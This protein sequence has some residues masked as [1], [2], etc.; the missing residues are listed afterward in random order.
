[1]KTGAVDLP[2]HTGKCPPW[3]F[4]R[5]KPLAGAVS[6]LVIDEYGTGELLK[7]ISDP[8]FFQSFAC[9]MG[10]DWHSSGASTT[11]CGALKEALAPDMG[12]AACGGKGKAS[13]KTP[14]EI[15]RHSD[16][17]SLSGAKRKALLEATRMTAKVDSSC[18]QDYHELYHHSF[19][20]D[21]RGNWAVVQQGMNDATG[22]ARRYHWRKTGNFTEAPPESIAGARTEG[23]LNLVSRKSRGVRESSLGFIQDNPARLRKYFTGQ[24]TLFDE[25]I[26]RLPQRH[27]ILRCDLTKKDW[28]ILNHAYE[29]QPRDYKELLMLQGM[30]KKKLRALALVSRLVYGNEL[31]WKDPVKYSFAHGGKDGIPH[32]VDRKSYDHTISFLRKSVEEAKLNEK[33][34]VGAL[35]RLAGLE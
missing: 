34:R 17:F 13:G 28:N 24:S 22:Y 27:E 32:P 33:D 26:K 1:M 18:V 11:A 2:L 5:M 15:S 7:R 3:L 31:D 8:M 12:I 35:K 23:T 14:S 20:M 29:I 19:F 6:Q 4:R 10:F 16:S 21:E 25:G 9:V 30:G